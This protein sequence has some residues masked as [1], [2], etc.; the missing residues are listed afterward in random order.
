MAYTGYIRLHRRLLDNP[1]IK[2]PLYCHLWNTLLLLAQHKPSEFIFAGERRRLL[3]GQFLTGRKKLA[4][5]S[6]ISESQVERILKYL[7]N[8]QQ[9][10]QDKTN[11]YRIITIVRWDSYQGNSSNDTTSEQQKDNKRTTEGHIQ[12]C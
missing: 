9:I 1:L 7:E 11:K 3:P 4:E 5:I 6:G 10:Q 2:K 12:E 8:A